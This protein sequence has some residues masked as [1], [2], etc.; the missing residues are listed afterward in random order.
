[1]YYIYSYVYGTVITKKAYD[2]FQKRE[3]EHDAASMDKEDGGWFETFYTGAHPY[4]TGY[5]GTIVGDWDDID[6]HPSTKMMREWEG[7]ITE[8]QKEEAQ[9]QFDALP[10]WLKAVLPPVGFHVCESTS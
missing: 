7:K 6:G 4:Q 10:E 8:D 9:R 5:L 1:M 3:D 2:T